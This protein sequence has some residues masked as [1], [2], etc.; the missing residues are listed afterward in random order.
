MTVRQ[1]PRAG[2]QRADPCWLILKHSVLAREWRGATSPYNLAVNAS[3]SPS[4]LLSWQRAPGSAGRDRANSS[5]PGRSRSGPPSAT[6]RESI[7]STRI[8]KAKP[9]VTRRP[10]RP[11]CRP[12]R[13]RRRSYCN[14]QVAP[15]RNTHPSF[16][17]VAQRGRFRPEQ[18]QRDSLPVLI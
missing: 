11:S 15:G 14:V 17:V 4:Q 3:S 10:S 16:H 1:V 7:R 2:R 9:S 13:D 18:V 6:G 8:S 5:V 12:N